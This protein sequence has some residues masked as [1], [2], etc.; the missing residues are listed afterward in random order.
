LEGYKICRKGDLVM[1][2]ML[3]WNRAL[4]V[5]A[6][7]GIVS[8]AYS[9]FQVVDGSDPSYLNYLL[10]TDG[11]TLYFKAHSA[12]V[13]DSRL[14]LYPDRFRALFSCLPPVEEQRAI[15]IFLD[16]ETARIDAL[17]AEQQRLIELLKEKRQAVISQLVTPTPGTSTTRLGHLVDLLPGFAFPSDEFSSTQTGPRLLRGINVGVGQCRWEEVVYWSEPV[18]ERLEEY[19]LREGDLVLG[20]DRPW[21]AEGTRVAR[22]GV[23]DL[24][25]LLVQRVSRLRVRGDVDPRFIELALS[26]REFRGALEADLTGVSVPHVS[27]SQIATFAVPVLAIKDQQRLAAEATAAIHSIEA[28]VDEAERAVALLQERRA[29]LISAAVTGKIDVRDLAAAVAA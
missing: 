28:L 22:V 18:G 6:Y 10:R 15:A 11:Y 19:A 29:A 16:Y 20:M 27:E 8:P 5:T 23:D 3:A 24:P 26:S 14:R 1:N 9:V 17:I 12:G 13:V 4:G 2:I 21:I 7:E 25:S